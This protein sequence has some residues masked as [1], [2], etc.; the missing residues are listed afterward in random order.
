[1]TELINTLERILH[2]IHKAEN[3]A[4]EVTYT[5]EFNRINSRLQMANWDINDALAV[6][7]WVREYNRK[8]KDDEKEYQEHCEAESMFDSMW[9]DQS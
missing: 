6:A 7:E 2:D 9:G 4:K 3:L 1:M 5:I 8:R